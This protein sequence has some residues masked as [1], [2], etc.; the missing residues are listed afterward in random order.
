[1]DRGFL[2]RI[3]SLQVFKNKNSNNVQFRMNTLS[4]MDFTHPWN[5][6]NRSNVCISVM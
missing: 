5:F 1:M 6:G 3:E 4:S 2:F